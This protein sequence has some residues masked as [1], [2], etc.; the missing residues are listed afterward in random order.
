[1][2]EEV[3]AWLLAAPARCVHSSS[4]S[5]LEAYYFHA[6]EVECIDKGKTNA[7]Y[8]FGAKV[9]IN[10][11]NAPAPGGQFVLHAK[12]LT[13][14]PQR[15]NQ[16]THGARTRKFRSRPLRLESDGSLAAMHHVA[17]GHVWTAPGWQEL[18]SRMQHWSVRPC[19]RPLSAVHVTAG[20]NALRGSGPGQ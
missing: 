2:L 7:P 5:V 17:K 4:A 16:T 20:H 12:A 14:N 10:I 13:G 19:V 15:S 8:E 3:F 1:V 9:S 18:F 11:P 6:L